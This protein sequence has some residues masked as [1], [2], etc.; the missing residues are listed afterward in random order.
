[1]THNEIVKQVNDL[2]SE[3]FE[4][5]SELFT[6]EANIRDVLSLDSLSLVDLVALI[7]QTYQIKVPIADLK[8]I[9]TFADLYQYIETHLAQKS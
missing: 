5:E 2:L 3:E 6:P 4:V 9:L 7:Q 8:N 1:M